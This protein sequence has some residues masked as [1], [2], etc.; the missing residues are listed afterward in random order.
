MKKVYKI[1]NNLGEKTLLWDITKQA[2]IVNVTQKNASQAQD[3]QTL[4]SGLKTTAK[5]MTN[6]MLPICYT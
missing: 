6:K 2:N 3:C 5:K 4:N 1:I